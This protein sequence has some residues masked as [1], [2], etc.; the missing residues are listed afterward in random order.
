MKFGATLNLQLITYESLDVRHSFSINVR[1]NRSLQQRVSNAVWWD[2]QRSQ[3]RIGCITL[4]HVQL[5]LAET[6]GLSRAASRQ[7][8]VPIIV[9]IIVDTSSKEGSALSKQ[10]TVKD[11]LDSDDED[12]SVIFEEALED[13]IID[14]ENNDPVNS[15]I[16]DEEGLAE[17]DGEAADSASGSDNNAMSS[18]AACS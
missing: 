18:E 12:E 7:L 14:V 4:Q 9:V 15:E 8:I 10:P 16:D 3:R 1:K 2:I 17:V 6:S 5:L 11:D 13:D